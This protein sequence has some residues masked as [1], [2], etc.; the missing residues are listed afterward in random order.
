MKKVIS[1]FLMILCMFS[2]LSFAYAEDPVDTEDRLDF[3]FELG[4]D[5]STYKTPT[6]SSK[7]EKGEY[8]PLTDNT[9]QDQ[10]KAI[11]SQYRGLI[12]FIYAI[13]IMTCLAG[14]IICSIKIGASGDNPQARQAGL[15]GILFCGA[16][17]ALLGFAGVWF[18]FAM[19]IL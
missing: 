13:M 3:K 16:G 2:M 8:E 14:L 19:K 11:Y 6:I 5:G 9:A 17:V 12:N 4:G 7:N 1:I 18:A 10:W 15:M